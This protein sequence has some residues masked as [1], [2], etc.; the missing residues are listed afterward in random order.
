MI[1]LFDKDTLCYEVASIVMLY[2]TKWIFCVLV[3][4]CFIPN[5]SP[6][7]SILKHPFISSLSCRQK[8]GHGT[9]W[10]SA[11]H[12]TTLKIKVLAGQLSHLE[13]LGKNPLPN[14]SK[15]LTESHYLRLWN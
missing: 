5:I 12:L 7:F 9:T 3:F 2:V 14:S 13:P 4:Y 11:Q 10:F 8:P 6:Q 1:I 15:L